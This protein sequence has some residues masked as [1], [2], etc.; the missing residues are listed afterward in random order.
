[1]TIDLLLVDDRAPIRQGLRTL[2][3]L[4]TD[5][6]VVGEAEHG[7]AALACLERVAVNVVLL[8]V[9][10]PVMD[11]VTAAKEISQR[12]PDV[13]I[14]MLTTFDDD[15]YVSAAIANGAKGYLL[16][17]T[18]SE[19][20]AAAVRAVAK[21]YTHLAPGILAKAMS[22][23]IDKPTAPPPVE[24]ATLTPRELEVLSAIAQGASN[25]E[26]AQRLYISE[27]TVKNHVTNLLNRLGLRDRTQAAIFANNY[28][29]RRSS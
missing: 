25:R 16:K 29:D 23:K 1:M 3:E 28:L 22:A 13:N 17:D 27:G 19:E 8:D 24:L 26:I 10:M 2:L 9:R 4:E 18:P 15:G 6:R 20:I 14:L 12:F 5:L 7:V 11:G 21:G